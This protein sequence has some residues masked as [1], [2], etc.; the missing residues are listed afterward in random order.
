MIE[1]L[2]LD[3]APKVGSGVYEGGVKPP[4]AETISPFVCD[5][6]L[7]DVTAVS[8]TVDDGAGTQF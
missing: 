3:I 6:S 7:V 2:V 1:V 4:G 5:V 8:A